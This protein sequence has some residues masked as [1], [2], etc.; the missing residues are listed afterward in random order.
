[1][2]GKTVG[3]PLTVTVPNRTLGV[4]TGTS[5]NQAPAGPG[6]L[7]IARGVVLGLLATL[8]LIWLYQEY[9][10]GPSDEYY[11]CWAESISYGMSDSQA[12]SSCAYL[13]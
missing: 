11:S 7:T 8:A 13:R 2:K 1:M 9:V 5:T 4:M 10:A 3:G 6:V 12:S